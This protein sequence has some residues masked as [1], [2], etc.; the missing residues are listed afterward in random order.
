METIKSNH[1]WTYSIRGGLAV[2]FGSRCICDQ[3]C[4]VGTWCGFV[5]G[6]R[7]SPALWKTESLLYSGYS[8]FFQL[9]LM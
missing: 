8:V 1:W 6:Y 7:F 5:Q 3:F 4:F 2:L 9:F